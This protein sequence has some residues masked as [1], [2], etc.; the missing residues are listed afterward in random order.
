VRLDAGF[1]DAANLAWLIPLGY[2]VLAKGY[3]GKR[4]A[5]YARRIKPSEGQEIQPGQRWLAW[6]PRQLRFSRP[7]RTVA[8]RW[9]TPQ[10]RWKHA[11]SITTLSELSLHEIAALYE[12]RASAAGAI[13][14]DQSGLVLARRRQH[15]CA[16]QEMLIL[17]NDWVHNRRAWFHADVLRRTVFDGF[18]PK[19]IMRDLFTIP[20]QAVIVDDHLLE[21]KLKQ[22]HPYAAPMADCLTKLWHLHSLS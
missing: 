10:A 19:R 12:D 6:S 4:A 7:T 8:V 20:A 21:L 13:Q 22:A 5:A 15:A 14:A 18:A 16:A 9:L 1:G 3:S 2:Q 17:R 11:L